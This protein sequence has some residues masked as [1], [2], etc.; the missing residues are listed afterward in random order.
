MAT[1]FDKL[2]ERKNYF[3]R[4]SYRKLLNLNVILLWIAVALATTL[5]FFVLTPGTPN[6]YAS[7]TTGE[8][9]TMHSLGQPVVTDTFVLKWATL[10]ASQVYNLNF[11]K[12]PE[13]LQKLQMKFTENGWQALMGSLNAGFLKQLKSNKLITSAVV[14]GVPVISSRY[15]LHNRYTWVVEFPLLVTYQSANLTRQRRLLIR[16]RIMRVPVLQVPNGIQ[17]EGF[18]ASTPQ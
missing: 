2:E 4:D 11:S 8:V 14:G 9:Y 13:Q 10:L 6:Y 12:Y 7:T 1:N 15:M 18:I 3:F 5:A 16:M 17:C